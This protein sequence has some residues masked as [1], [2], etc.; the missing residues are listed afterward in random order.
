MTV[1]TAKISR[2]VIEAGKSLKVI[3]RHGVGYD[4]VDLAAA[5]ERGIPVS[6]TVDANAASVAEQ[7][8]A[9]V[10][11]LA[12]QVPVFSSETKAGNWMK[13]RGEVKTRD[14]AALG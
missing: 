8:M 13:A 12:K 2:R 4:N 10:L 5:S 14:I 7:T 11:A 6:I 3:A 1:R 9:F